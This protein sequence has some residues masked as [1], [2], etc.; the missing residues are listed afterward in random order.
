MKRISI[1][2]FVVVLFTSCGGKSGTEIAQEVCD[3][4]SKANDMDPADPKR[5]E[6]QNTCATK[7]MEAWNKVKDDI[8]KS[9][10]FNKKLSECGS[11]QLKK[12]F[13]K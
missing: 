12:A 9:D 11:E 7:Q 1:L 4:T 13:K 8:N 5:A 3:C 2:L 10:E 6:A